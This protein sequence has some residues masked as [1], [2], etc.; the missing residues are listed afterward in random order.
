VG[1]VS[2]SA[3]AVYLTK[4]AKM[5]PFS[6]LRGQN[7][8]G[9][10]FPIHFNDADL[11]SWHGSKL[12]TSA[13]IGQMDVRSDL[14]FL[15]FADI[16][17]GRYS[18]GNLYFDYQA[19]KG[20]LNL[21]AQTCDATG[22]VRLVNKDFDLH[23][24]GFSYS[25][26]TKTVFSPGYIT[27]V[28]GKGDVKTSGVQYSLKSGNLATGPIQ[29]IGELRIGQQAGIPDSNDLHRWQINGDRGTQT[30]K[31]GVTTRTFINGIATDGNILV[32]SP[33][34][35]WNPKTDVIVCTGGVHYFSPKSNV[36]CDMATIYR[37]EKKSVL[38]GHVVMYVKPKDQETL[39]PTM[40][41]PPFVPV[42]PADI[43]KE[44]PPA[45]MLED[46]T[47]KDLNDQLRDTGTVRKYPAVVQAEHIIYFY[48]QGS[49]HALINGQ[50]QAQQ[51]LPGNRWRRIWAQ[52]AFY[53]GEKDTL[54]M[55]G[56]FPQNPVVVK[57]S[58]GDQMNTDW[59]E[60]STL[61]G[62]E[63]SSSGKQSGVY[64]SDDSEANK[65]AANAGAKDKES[66][67]KTKS[68]PLKGSGG[69]VVS[70]GT[71]GSTGASGNGGLQG[72]IGH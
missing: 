16:T 50:P 41:V 71:S 15:K 32:K 34:V 45:P 23:G 14:R 18:S 67:G 22:P 10:T 69:K 24:T 2:A 52:T 36:V 55:V 12:L 31:N 29:W 46:P 17:Q 21:D 47:Q 62:D 66:Q 27:G 37:K 1:V 60:V 51:E 11:K 3:L 19:S 56:T 6:N 30:T 20:N 63:D 25:L 38:D 26:R 7:Q 13:K 28:I 40:K 68:I 70:N 65:E 35:V 72:P 49:R 9:L 39:D 54:R 58:L 61:D 57:D 48:E 44:R 4:V 8:S 33:L 64:Y 43:S 5:D 42:V 59:L 53:D